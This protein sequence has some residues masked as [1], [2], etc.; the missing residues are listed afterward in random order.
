MGSDRRRWR[1]TWTAALLLPLLRA[2]ATRADGSCPAQSLS[3]SE[4]PSTGFVVADIAGDAVALRIKQRTLSHR[5]PFCTKIRIEQQPTPNDSPLMGANEFTALPTLFNGHFAWSNGPEAISFVPHADGDGSRGN[6]LLGP[7]PGVDNGYVYRTA[8]AADLSPLRPAPPA[9][10]DDGGDGDGD[11]DAQPWHWLLHQ[12]WTPQRQMFVACADDDRDD[13]DGDGAD[14]AAAGRE[15]FEVEFFAAEDEAPRSGLL[16]P[17][18]PAAFR[19]LLG[20]DAAA[21]AACDAAR[22]MHLWDAQTAA[23]RPLTVARTIAAVGSPVRLVAPAAVDAAPD[24]TGGIVSGAAAA[25]V[26]GGAAERREL[27]VLVGAELAGA[28]GWRLFFHLL[29]PYDPPLV[30]RNASAPQRSAGF[31]RVDELYV[32]LD[33]AGRAAG[34]VVVNEAPL[35]ARRRRRRQERDLLRYATLPGDFV[36]LWETRAAGPSTAAAKATAAG[37]DTARHER[38][39]DGAATATA[40]QVDEVLVVCTQRRVDAAG[41]VAL[42]FASFPSH[43]QRLMAQSMAQRLVS[44]YTV[45]LPPAADDDADEGGEG[46]VAAV[47]HS[48]AAGVEGRHH[49]RRRTAVRWTTLVPL[50]ARPATFLVE[51]LRWK[52]HRVGARLSSCFLYHAAVTLPAPLVYAA[53][54][55]CVLLGS[56]PVAMVQLS[57]PSEHQWKFPLVAALARAVVESVDLH[58]AAADAANASLPVDYAVFTFGEDETLVVYRAHRRYLMEALRPRFTAQAL[59]PMP[60]PSHHRHDADALRRAHRE[61]LYNAAWNGLALGYPAYFVRAYVDGFGDNDV[62]VADRAA[63]YDAAAR[64][65]AR[66]MPRL[67]RGAVS[68]RGY[69]IGYG[70]DRDLLLRLVPPAADAATGATAASRQRAE[71]T[72]AAAQRQRQLEDDWLAALWEA[73][74]RPGAV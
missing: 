36:W 22:V 49:A 15:Y 72:G 8:P 57:S 27:G 10:D 17:A 5:A 13:R 25:A 4:L 28:R 62:A 31:Y 37:G 43:R 54:L 47:L 59:H 24:A 14:G 32:E 46:G 55:L 64:D 11:E 7:A 68:R 38:I 50:S 1:G 71:S 73:A 29:P 40:A 65:F 58:R 20:E 19:A 41:R 67:S 21:A 44:H 74:H 66:D 42:S 53:E 33:A 70:L 16:F 51:H 30:A 48:F 56:K 63:L 39:V 18:L 26:D 60:F 61:Q 35:A 2:A 34:G 23:L 12:Q 69:E 3:A 45:V 6:W 52:E 9:D